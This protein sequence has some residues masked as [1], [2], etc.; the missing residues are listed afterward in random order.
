MSNPPERQWYLIA[1]D[2]SDDKRRVRV[3]KCLQGYG[4][5]IQYSV[6]RAYLGVRAMARLRWELS[7]K[8]DPQDGLLIVPLCARCQARVQDQ[9]GARDWREE[10]P[11]GYSIAGQI[12][13]LPAEEVS[14]DLTGEKPGSK[15]RQAGRRSVNKGKASAA[16]T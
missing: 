14:A 3:A 10:A 4:E 11:L 2:V 16:S 6:F 7:G 13:H 1:Y 15:P 9:R 12:T 8:M 5:R